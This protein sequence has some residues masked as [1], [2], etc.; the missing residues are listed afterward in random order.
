MTQATFAVPREGLPELTVRS[1]AT[2]MLIG[3]LLTPCN[4]YSGLKIGWTFNMSVAAGLIAFA[5]WN[6]AQRS[7]STP[8]F[9]LRENNINQTAASSA[10]SII[11]AGLAA[12]IPALALLTGQTLTFPVLAVW[13]FVVSILGVVVAAGLR[14]QLL[15]RENLPFPAGI[16]TA[17]TMREIHEG[18]EEA[19]ARLR[20][21]GTAAG[22]SAALK[23]IVAGFGI[24][25]FGLPLRTTL[26]LPGSAGP[27]PVTGMNLGFALDPSLLMFGFGAIAGL[28]IGIS[29]L[30][31][32]LLGWAV[33]APIAL[34]N[35]W[36]VPGELNP[37]VLWFGPVVEW[38]LWPGATLMVTASLTAFVISLVR[39][40]ASRKTRL[41]NARS[42]RP[43]SDRI[44]QKALSAAFVV[45]LAMC[46]AAQTIIF[47]INLFEA[48][49][50]VLL[51][52]V[53]AIVAARV[54]GETAITPVGALG[55]ITQ[56][57]FGALS[58]GNVTA[59]LMTA[60][61]TGGAAGQCADLM[62]DL[63]TGLSL[64]A[65]PPA[66]RS[67]LRSSA[68]SRAPW[69]PRSHISH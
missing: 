6:A 8:V 39:L 57:T 29:M 34:E 28:R 64:S 15:F 56:L 27:T 26:N 37:D 5:F 1:V 12:P 19:S 24:G 17:E 31:G 65:R 41:N 45:V 16:V 10:A 61:V 46:I 67:S 3:A 14:N 59:N 25:Q 13:M 18:G 66:S 9:G 60:N 22:I 32:A 42:D 30:I 50:A 49:V 33:L 4:V 7:L 51:S 21:L 58:P 47:D 69:S 43:S 20:L 53:L 62:H 44:D 40:V 38:L 68:F 55:K 48:T 36:A 52:Y 63:R 35:G 2:G 23:S 54:S 11:S